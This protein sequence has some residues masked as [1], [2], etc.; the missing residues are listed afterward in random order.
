[1]ERCRKANEKS[2]LVYTRAIVEDRPLTQWEKQ[3]VHACTIASLRALAASDF[4]DRIKRI[5]Q[6]AKRGPLHPAQI[7]MLKFFAR[8]GF[9][10]AVKLLQKCSQ[11]GM[12]SCNDNLPAI[13]AG[14]A[15]SFR[16]A[17]TKVEEDW[18]LR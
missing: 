10:E 8:K 1:M 15:K 9:P 3:R 13:S 5:K 18:Q 6:D 17:Q 16:R 2:D 4:L 12:R 14:V 11:S 7:K